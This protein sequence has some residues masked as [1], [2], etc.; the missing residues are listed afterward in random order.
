MSRRRPGERAADREREPDPR[1]G[2]TASGGARDARPGGFASTLGGQL[3]ILAVVFALAVLV[4]ELAGAANLGVAL[5]V[6]QIA[7]AVV[8]VYLLLKR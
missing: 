4:A 5:G 8:L 6:G 1:E 2:G 3:V 7:F